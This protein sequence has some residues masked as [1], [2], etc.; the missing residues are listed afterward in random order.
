MNI[1]RKDIEKAGSLAELNKQVNLV[2]LFVKDAA[3]RFR[4][5]NAD[6]T[7]IAELRLKDYLRRCGTVTTTTDSVDSWIQLMSVTGD[8]HDTILA[9]TRLTAMTDVVR[10][11]NIKD[12]MEKHQGF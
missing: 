11:R 6:K 5:I 1:S 2:A 10:W 9:F 12:S 4:D 8:F 3:N 7:I